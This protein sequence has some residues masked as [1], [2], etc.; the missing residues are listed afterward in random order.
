MCDLLGM[1][2]NIPVNA[3]ISLDVFQ[4]RGEANPDGWGMAFYRAGLLQVIKEPRPSVKSTLYDFIEGDPNSKI[5]ISHVR[6]STMGIR[7]Y[8]NTHPFYRQVNW[9]SGA[10]EFVLAHNGTIT[11]I[12]TLQLREYKPIGGTDSEHIFCHIL[13]TLAEHKITEWDDSAFRLIENT[14]RTINNGKNTI[15]CIFSDGE[16]LFCYSDENQ[17]NGGLRFVHRD[18]PF[19]IIDLVRHDE[20]LGM[21]DIRTI[22]LSENKSP[23][24]S[25]YIIVTKELTDEDWIEFE[26]GELI[27]FRDGKIIHPTT[28]VK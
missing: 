22:N 5:F 1:S 17:H 19:G 28:R 24:S 6:R 9:S 3:R 8:L 25:G 4:L 12:E 27:V 15:N 7:S 20:K 10:K 2:F 18:Q 21:I 13:D 16:F 23:D 11:D 26:P 14:L